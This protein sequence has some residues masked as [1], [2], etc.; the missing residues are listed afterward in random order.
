MA[1]VLVIASVL[2]LVLVLL[3][4]FET[5]VLPRCVTRRFRLTRIFYRTLWIPGA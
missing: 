1:I 4:G 5:M 2:L 3:D